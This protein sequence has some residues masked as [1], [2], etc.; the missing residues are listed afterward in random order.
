[1]RNFFKRNRTIL[2]IFLIVVVGIAGFLYTRGANADPTS[3]FQTTTIERGNLTATIGATGTVRPKQ[4]TV[5]VWQAAGTV[6][7]V[8]TNVGESVRAEQVLAVLSKTSLPQSIILAEADLI[9]AQKSLDDLMNSNTAQAEAVVALRDA[10][11]AY[12]KA[13]NYYDSLFKP[14]EYDRIVYKR[15]QTPFGMKRIPEI[16]TVKVDKADDETI[17]NAGQDLALAKSKLDDAQRNYDLLEDGNTAEIVAAQARLDAAQ[18]TL[19]MA[20]LTAPFAGTVTESY[21]LPGDQVAAGATAFRLDDLSS[22]YVDVQVSEVD[23]NSVALGQPATLTFDAILDREYHGQVV[24]VAS[25]GTVDQGVVNFK[26]TVQLL[27]AD[28]SVKPGMTAAVNIV[29]EEIQDVVLVPNRAVRLVDGE[30]VVYLLIDGQS[31]KKEIRLGSSSDT[32]SVVAVGDVQEGDVV[33]L[34]PPSLEFGPGGG[35]GG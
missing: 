35:F 28:A 27:D 29:V 6:E 14:Y 5:L 8:H 3:G 7:D 18:A 10:Q 31:I 24:E 13:E 2:I 25:V 30:R 15:K 22:L 26:V 20:R 16:K 11:E 19:N 17:K 33:I 4:S 1:M 9:N 12:E 23:I 21:P 32:M 34:N